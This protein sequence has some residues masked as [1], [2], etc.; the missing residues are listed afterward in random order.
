MGRSNRREH[1]RKLKERRYREWGPNNL[2]RVRA[3]LE[4]FP[5]GPLP[6]RTR[7]LVARGLFRGW[8]SL[9]GPGSRSSWVLG[10]VEEI[11]WDPPRL[12]FQVWSRC[13]SPN[14][15][16]RDLQRWTVDLEQRRRTVTR[17]ERRLYDW[18]EVHREFDPVLIGEE[19]AV[20]LRT[21]RRDPRLEW[22]KNGRARLRVREFLP[23]LAK[24]HIQRRRRAIEAVMEWKLA[25]SRLRRGDG[26][27][28][29]PAR[30]KPKPK[31][32][33]TRAVSGARFRAAW[34]HFHP[35]DD[36]QLI[37]RFLSQAR[38]SRWDEESVRFA[39]AL[40]QELSQRGID[41]GALAEEKRRR[42]K[43]TPRRAHRGGVH[44]WR[45]WALRRDSSTG[46]FLLASP[47][48]GT[49]WEGPVL[50]AV[51]P[52][53]D[54]KLWNAGDGIYSWRPDHARPSR[55]RCPVHGHVMNHGTVVAHERGF[56]A[57]HAL[58]RDLTLRFCPDPP[59]EGSLEVGGDIVALPTSENPAFP[60]VPV[61]QGDWAEADR[62][63]L[64]LSR[65]YD[66]PVAVQTLTYAEL[67]ALWKS[68]A[69]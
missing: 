52:S 65:R 48:L 69:R 58:V 56:R 64:S 37:E 18:R 4:S 60:S 59:Y 28:W 6:V 26:G 1:Q 46:E 62:I 49:L 44:G 24:V 11:R 55:M 40:L 53:G 5:P 30:R 13:D 39:G 19:L 16:R 41:P 9:A 61:P 22:A 3:R 68:D 10:Q 8:Y 38:T 35:L 27:W 20:M 2:R 17:V 42:A 63:A 7:R 21:G 34:K 14:G 50:H 45:E 29:G 51:L 25:R 67:E 66:C 54:R 23:P 12:T 32:S 57:E 33:G 47:H 36:A 31:R 15:G 43:G